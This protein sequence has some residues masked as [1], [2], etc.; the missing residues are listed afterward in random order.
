MFSSR[1]SMK[2]SAMK[3]LFPNNLFPIANFNDEQQSSSLSREQSLQFISSFQTV[4]VMNAVETFI[5]LLHFISHFS[6]KKLEAGQEQL[7]TMLRHNSESVGKYWLT[8]K[9]NFPDEKRTTAEDVGGKTLPNFSQ[10]RR[11]ENQ[12]CRLPL[13]LC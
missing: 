7:R 4:H 2:T 9:V 6:S 5:G 13:I 10:H 12:H 1:S 3:L 11:T 8:E